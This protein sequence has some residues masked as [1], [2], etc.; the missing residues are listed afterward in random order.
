M[1]LGLKSLMLFLFWMD[2]ERL[3]AEIFDFALFE[4]DL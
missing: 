4:G 2:F 3:G 1:R